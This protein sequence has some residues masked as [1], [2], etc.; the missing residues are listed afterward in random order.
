[1]GLACVM[2][3]STT[4]IGVFAATPEN[5]SNDMGGVVLESVTPSTTVNLNSGATTQTISWPVNGAYGYWK[6]QVD[7]TCSDNINI[8][9]RKNSPTGTVVFSGTVL[10]YQEIPFYCEEKAPLTTGSYYITLT[11]RG[12]ANLN[13][14]LHY[15]FASDYDELF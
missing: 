4:C 12:D 8:R 9:I 5:S 13:G 14:Q 10:P 6:I 11:T 15:K 3:V 2:A 1:M 7:S